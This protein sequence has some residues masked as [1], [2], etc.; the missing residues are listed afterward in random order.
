M[1]SKT[2]GPAILPSLLICP[3]NMTG[4][5]VLFPKLISSAVQVFSCVIL[6]CNESTVFVV[7]V[8][9][10]SIIRIFGLIFSA[11]ENIF[12]NLFSEYIRHSLLEFFILLALIFI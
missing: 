10:E 12:S 4:I 7:K 1:C 8:W 6:P 2:F 5:E 11:C 3:I 9:I